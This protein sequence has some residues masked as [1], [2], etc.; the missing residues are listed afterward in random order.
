MRI[1]RREMLLGSAASMLALPACSAAPTAAPVLRPPPPFEGAIQAANKLIGADA[2]DP[3]I[4][5][6]AI[7]LLF[8]HEK[9]V[10]RAVILF[11][12]FT[13]CPKQFEEL[14][15]A[16][17]RR[18]C[19]VFIPR[20]PYHGYKDRLTRALGALTTADLQQCAL[21]TFWIARGLGSRVTAL[22]LSLG[23]AMS[24]WLAQNTPIDLAVPVAPFL[25]PQPLTRRSGMVFAT[26]L[27]ALP[28]MY[29]WWDPR[30]KDQSLP[31][32][33]YPGYPTH[34]L[35]ELIFFG[36][37]IDSQAAVI[38]PLGQRCVLVTNVHDN[39]V[40]PAINERVLANWRQHNPGYSEYRFTDLLPPRHDII[41]PTTYPQ[42][43]TLV[44]PTLESI[45]LSS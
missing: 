11:H 10:E 19:N 42:G 39:A 24:M 25:V 38:P 17:F 43:R 1:S 31:L 35:A 9:R 36:N 44:Y 37:L 21:D 2:A 28:D 13:N 4:E 3:T 30:V 14:G 33:A 6:E 40:D 29:W 12:G 27:H 45:G 15:H 41:D 5:R 20:L 32:Y 8:T 34:A 23:G 26:T 18:G 22:G 16:F 7:P